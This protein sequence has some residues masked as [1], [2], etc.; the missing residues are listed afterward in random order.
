V[1]NTALD[2]SGNTFDCAGDFGAGG[3]PTASTTITAKVTVLSAAPPPQL[4]TVVTADPDLEIAESDET[5]N[6]KTEKT[7]VSGTV[8]GTPS[9][10]DLFTLVTGPPLIGPSPGGIGVYTVNVQNIGTAPVPDSPTTWSTNI[11]VV[12][13]LISS[14][15]PPP[16]V[17]CTPSP[18]PLVTCSSDSGDPDGM[19]L[20]PGAI[21]TFQVTVLNLQ[22]SGGHVI[23]ITA[24]A[25]STN[26]ITESNEGNNSSLWV[27]ATTP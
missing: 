13:G 14:V 2:P 25:D 17:T 12:G 9:C 3:S 23:T 15:A 6:E 21:A 10:V 22:G 26:A 1:K 4:T 8:C 27:I 24:N 19:D 7:T 11:S 5:N 20:A 16:G 18:S